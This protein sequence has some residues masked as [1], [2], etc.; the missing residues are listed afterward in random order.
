[1]NLP[2]RIGNIC[3]QLDAFLATRGAQTWAFVSAFNPCSAAL[4]EQENLA[5]HEDLLRAVMALG[6]EYYEGE[7]RAD[8]ADWPPEKSLLI[9]AIAPEQVTQLCKQFGQYAAVIGA[10]AE[11]A[12]LLWMPSGSGLV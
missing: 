9:I 1:M 11:P 6:V 4:C 7:S 5:R 3:P 2:I 12:K 10:I 8:A